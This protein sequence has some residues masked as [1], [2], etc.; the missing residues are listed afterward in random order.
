MKDFLFF[1]LEIDFIL[2]KMEVKYLIILIYKYIC[3]IFIFN[4]FFYKRIKKIKRLKG[5]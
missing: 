3:N 1:L 5:D 2:I 4:V